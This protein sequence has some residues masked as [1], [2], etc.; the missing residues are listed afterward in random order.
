[1]EKEVFIGMGSNLGERYHF[2]IRGI[3]VLKS[4]GA[5][6]INASGIYETLP[7]GNQ[8]QPAYLN[9][10]IQIGWE[11]TAQELLEILLEIEMQFGRVRSEKWGARTLDLDILAF[12]NTIENTPS[13]MIPHPEIRNRAF[14]LVPWAEITPDYKLPGINQTIKSLCEQL[15]LEE[16]KTVYPSMMPI[17]PDTLP[18]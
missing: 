7:W 6:V 8:A 9:A 14:V 3:E 16:L 13:L 17:F 11:G 4:K 15:P 1:M 2:L 5:Q 18:L 10:V 12:G